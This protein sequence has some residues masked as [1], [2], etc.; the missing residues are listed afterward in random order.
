MSV[1]TLVESEYSVQN[2]INSK[3][4]IKCFVRRLL[5]KIEGM[6][7]ILGFKKCRGL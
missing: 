3:Q 7:D 2:I 4:A 6:Y 1:K 5:K